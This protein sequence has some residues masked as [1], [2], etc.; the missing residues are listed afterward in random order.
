[1]SLQ[2]ISLKVVEQNKFKPHNAFAH[3]WQI[4][5]K[6]PSSLLLRRTLKPE[7][8]VLNLGS[9]GENENRLPHYTP[10]HPS[11]QTEREK[12]ARETRDI[13]CIK[14]RIILH[15]LWIEIY[16]LILT[17]QFCD[18]WKASATC[19]KTCL[20]LCKYY[21]HEGSLVLTFI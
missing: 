5:S 16:S 6:T 7:A 9:L 18:I 19:W 10:R 13:F 1:M 2:L 4:Q 20:F 12:R 14:N 15:L 21:V 3:I 8:H 11:S 17:T